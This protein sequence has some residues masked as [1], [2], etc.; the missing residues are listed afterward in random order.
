MRT[1]SS[2]PG[3]PKHGPTFAYEPL[4]VKHAL[5]AASTGFAVGA[6]FAVGFGVGFG[7]SF[8]VG[9]EA[10]FSVGLGVGTNLTSGT[11]TLA[12]LL[13]S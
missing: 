9:V 3:A 2:D 4:L 6:G 5:I 8:G 7:V 12:L 10:G 11:K 13:R 1:A